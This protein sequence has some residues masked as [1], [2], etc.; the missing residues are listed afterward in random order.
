MGDSLRQPDLYWK[1]LQELKAAC[2][3]IR[4]YRN[5]LSRRLRLIEIVKAIGSSGGIAGWIVWKDIPFVWT[6]IIAAS[7]LLDALK[8]VF[9]LAKSHKAANDLTVALEVLYIDAEDEWESIYA[10]RLSADAIVK[11]R[12]R[13]RKLQ[14]VEERKHFPDGLELPADLIR[15]ATIE[16]K[17]YFEASSVRS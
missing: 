13:L 4:L 3:C 2:I 15:L 1:Q 9:P 17:A 5:R 6:A 8:N 7:Q 12:T 14:L 10:G 11:R 16:A